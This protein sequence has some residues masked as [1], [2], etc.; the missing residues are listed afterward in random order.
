MD[1]VYGIF[2]LNLKRD[3]N[4]LRSIDEIDKVKNEH[5]LYEIHPTN[6]ET[7]SGYIETYNNQLIDFET[8]V[9]YTDKEIWEISSWQEE[10]P[11]FFIQII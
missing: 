7:I 10:H 3:E 6:N 2:D 1:D 11:G 8:K 9:L 4:I 5:H